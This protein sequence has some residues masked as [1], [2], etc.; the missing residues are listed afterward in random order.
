MVAFTSFLLRVL[1][2]VTVSKGPSLSVAFWD[3]PAKALPALSLRELAIVT[4]GRSLDVRAVPSV[5]KTSRGSRCSADAAF[6]PT[7]STSRTDEIVFPVALKAPGTTVAESSPLSSV[8]V[9][10]IEVVE[11]A[12]T[13]AVVDFRRAPAALD[14]LHRSPVTTAASTG[15]VPSTVMSRVLLMVY[16]VLAAI[17]CPALL[18]VKASAA[19]VMPVNATPTVIVPVAGT[20]PVMVW[21]SVVPV[22][23]RTTVSVAP[24]SDPAVCTL[25][26]PAPIPTVST[27]VVLVPFTLAVPVMLSALNRSAVLPD[28]SP[29]NLRVPLPAPST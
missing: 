19:V 16:P 24:S 12:D 11:P 10:R 14:A 8:K 7:T 2:S 15:A 21:D 13:V 9:T 4:V 29:S 27:R 17:S 20:N 26:P 18:M 6:S 5:R 28:P 25:V 3:A 1:S 23:A 22:L